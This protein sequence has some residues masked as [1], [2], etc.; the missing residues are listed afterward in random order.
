MGSFVCR[1]YDTGRPVNTCV[2]DPT[3][4]VYSRAP[5]GSAGFTASE[6]GASSA[7]V[8]DGDVEGWK[9]ATEGAPVYASADS[10]CA[11]S[12][13]DAARAPI[14]TR[15]QPRHR[16]GVPTVIAFLGTLAVVG[17]VWLRARRRRA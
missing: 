8:H 11:D 2:G 12:T 5:A 10:V 16:S 15:Y 17:V 1:L 9:W 3:Y 13:T 6:V 14:Q 4:W 7:E